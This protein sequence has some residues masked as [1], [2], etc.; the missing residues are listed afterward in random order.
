MGEIWLSDRE[1]HV[2]PNASLELRINAA[3][4]QSDGSLDQALAII[5]LEKIRWETLGPDEYE[6]SWLAQTVMS[7]L[8][9]KIGRK[10]IAGLTALAM[11][12]LDNAGERMS[13]RM[14][15]AVV[16]EFANSIT[17]LQFVAWK[18]K[19]LEEGIKPLVGDEAT[20]E[21]IF[22]EYRSVAH[23]CAAE[24]ASADYLDFAHP[25]EVR[26]EADACFISTALYYQHRM[27]KAENF[28]RWALKEIRFSP[29]YAPDHYPPLLATEQLIENLIGPWLD[30]KGR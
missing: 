23:I 17:G 29:P 26:P 15:A 18:G 25:F 1:H 6:P 4:P 22:R 7:A 12:S 16:S 19:V 28:D 5:E 13:L 21:K 30:S 14:A 2:R 11:A 8:H 9:R 27:R 3:L 10:T 24:V 20:I